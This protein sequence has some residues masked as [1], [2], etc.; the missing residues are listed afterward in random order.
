MSKNLQVFHTKT[1]SFVRRVRLGCHLASWW[2]QPFTLRPVG[3][4]STVAPTIGFLA[5][6]VEPQSVSLFRGCFWVG[7]GYQFSGIGWLQPFGFWLLGVLG[8]LRP[9]GMA[10]AICFLVLGG[11]LKWFQSCTVLASGWLQRSSFWLSEWLQL[12][13]FWLLG[14]IPRWLQPFVG[15]GSDSGMGPTI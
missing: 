13:S 6:G 9:L 15:F 1:R 11:A 3:G 8:L 10:S 5:S 7:S 14:R 12:L 2:L 4:G